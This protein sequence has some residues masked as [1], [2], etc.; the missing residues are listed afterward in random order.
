M[1]TK[2]LFNTMAQLCLDMIYP[3]HCALCGKTL[4]G[5]N[6]V[7]VCGHCDAQS[8]KTKVVKDDRFYF[9]EAIGAVKYQ[10]SVKDAMI[11]FKF[12]ATKYYGGAYAHIMD[13]ASGDRPYFKEAIMCCVPLSKSRNRDY[14]QTEV[15]ARQ[16]AHMWNSEFAADLLY[17]RKSV[18]Q[19]SKM[20]L[21][22]R[23]F[24]IEGVFDVNPGYDIYS[25][26]ILIIDDIFT[27]GTTANEC[28]KVLKMHGAERVFVLCPCYD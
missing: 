18:G 15:M 3:R 22:E 19:I 26:D 1:E 23:R 17:R 16:L 21:P 28:A 13:R 10:D 27:S 24:F 7:A 2:R 8:L 6:R 20:K 25:R 5:Y 11:K 4:G 14:S 12:K 9:D